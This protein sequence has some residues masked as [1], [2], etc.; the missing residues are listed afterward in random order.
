MSFWEELKRRH[1]FRVSA[2]YAVVAWLLVQVAAV[3]L[4]AFELP[5]WILQTF[6]AFIALGFVVALV[7]A[8]IYDLTPQGLKRTDDMS[9]ADRA[10]LPI[11]RKLDFIVIAL[12]FVAVA[13]LGF[14]KYIG[15]PEDGISTPQVQSLAVL[16]FA[17]RSSDP[18]DAY[19]ADGLADELL[20]VLGRVREES[21]GEKNNVTAVS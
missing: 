5:S 19:F 20:S 1:I 8:W 16:A 21:L 18:E 12:L 10:V 7:L 11:G 13:F 3:V 6:L 17:N 2:T 9:E 14:S 15:T 4:P